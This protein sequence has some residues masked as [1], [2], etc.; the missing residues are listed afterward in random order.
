MS[1]TE[2]RQRVVDVAR[3]WLGTPYHSAARVKGVGVDC[4][5]VL[6]EVYH[7]AGIIGHVD[8]PYYPNDFMLHSV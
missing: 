7:E 4:L 6:A 1:E 3:T 5:T 2:Q 8:I